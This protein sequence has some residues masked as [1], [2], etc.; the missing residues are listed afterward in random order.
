M[1]R[2]KRRYRPAKVLRVPPPSIDA[3]GAMHISL[4]SPGIGYWMIHNRG[5]YQM[6]N[7]GG[8]QVLK[9]FY[10]RTA[11]MPKTNDDHEHW[12]LPKIIRQTRAKHRLN[13]A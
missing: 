1:Q 8:K 3:D 11:I 10:L 7:I 12:Y 6:W 5:D 13:R 9:L 2:T 4:G